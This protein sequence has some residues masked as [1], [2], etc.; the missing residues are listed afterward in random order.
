MTGQLSMRE[1]SEVNVR[2]LCCYCTSATIIFFLYIPGLI[3]AWVY[4][5]TRHKA[6]DQVIAGGLT[7]TFAL[8]HLLLPVVCCFTQLP[9]KKTSILGYL[10]I[11]LL[12]LLWYFIAFVYFIVDSKDESSKIHQ[13]GVTISA[14]LGVTVAA[15]LAMPFCVYAAMSMCEF[16]ICQDACLRL[17][18][19]WRLRKA[20][21]ITNRPTTYQT[22]E[23]YP[24][25]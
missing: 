3:L 11:Q 21:N 13:L 17:R 16:L 9:Y 14:L 12:V 6:E 15:A 19:R 22:I 18:R 10:T 5:G 23:N 7:I 8:V 2:N 24:R 20:L 4:T 1:D 25:Y